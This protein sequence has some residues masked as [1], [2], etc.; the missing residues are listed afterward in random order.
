M[1][2]DGTAVGPHDAAMV[3]LEHPRVIN[4]AGM[5]NDADLLVHG[6]GIAV[7]TLCFVGGDK[8]TLEMLLVG[9][10]AGWAF[11]GIALKGLNAAKGEHEAP[12]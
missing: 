3:P 2:A 5:R 8:S 11:I 7:D 1:Q 4:A 9:R 10:N 12:G 6:R